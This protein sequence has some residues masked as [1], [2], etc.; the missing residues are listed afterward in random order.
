MPT[1]AID[2]DDTLVGYRKYGEPGEWLEGAINAIRVLRKRGFTVVI[3]SCRTNWPEGR[4]EIAAKLAS[5]GLKE[6]SKLKIHDGP[7][8]PLAVAYVDDRAIE[9]ANDWVAT[10]D[11]LTRKG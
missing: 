8:K 2:W 6:S 11:R 4:E 5:V 10:V 9:F 1:I 7:G 3:H